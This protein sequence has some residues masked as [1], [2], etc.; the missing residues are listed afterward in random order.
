MLVNSITFKPFCTP[1]Q[2][3]NINFRGKI[4][5]VFADQLPQDKFVSNRSK[6]EENIVT[7]MGQKEYE[8]ICQRADETER[9]ILSNLLGKLDD[10]SIIIMVG[11]TERVKPDLE[12]F[13]ENEPNVNKGIKKAYVIHNS[14]Y[15]YPVFITTS[16]QTNIH[17]DP[18]FMIHSKGKLRVQAPWWSPAQ[19]RTVKNTK[20]LTYGDVVRVDLDGHYIKLEKPKYQDDKAQYKFSVVNDITDLDEELNQTLDD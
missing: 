14:N 15:E 10:R 3:N 18:M 19:V 8:K 11:N 13:L 16:K 2:T 6:H 17:E 12:S 5:F 20:Y 4:G 1:K 7:V 9:I